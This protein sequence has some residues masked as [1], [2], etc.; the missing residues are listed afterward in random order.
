MHCSSQ[1]FFLFCISLVVSHRSLRYGL[2]IFEKND[3]TSPLKIQVTENFEICYAR[4]LRDYQRHLRLRRI[5]IVLRLSILF[6]I[7]I[8]LVLLISIPVLLLS[9]PTAT[10]STSS[11]TEPITPTS[12]TTSTKHTT[13]TALS[14]IT[15]TT[16]KNENLTGLYLW[17][18]SF[19]HSVY[20]IK[21]I[22]VIG[23]C[24]YSRLCQRSVEFWVPEKPN[25]SCS[26][27]D[28]PRSFFS[29][30]PTIPTI[31]SQVSS[32]LSIRSI[33]KHFF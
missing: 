29:Q 32:Q 16:A 10:T 19:H 25:N 7:L 21:G 26:L 31:P 6:L 23:G 30:L 17:L 1:Y 33:V 8:G 22:L 13:E 24:P 28:Y 3:S 18:P 20:N 11:S 15:T 14:T 2:N 9:P 27:T 12:T 4:A 5:Q